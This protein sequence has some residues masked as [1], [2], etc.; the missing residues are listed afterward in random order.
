MLAFIL[1]H[2]FRL[3][4]VLN[5][6]SFFD[7]EVKSCLLLGCSMVVCCL[8]HDTDVIVGADVDCLEFFYLKWLS[9]MVP[10]P[11]SFKETATYFRS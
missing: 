7:Q 6:L 1:L 3:L 10:L 9:I 4:G 11:V 2:S 5:F 8:S